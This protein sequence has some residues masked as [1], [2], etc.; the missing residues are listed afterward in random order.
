SIPEVVPTAAKRELI[1]RSRVMLD[2][3]KMIGRVAPSDSTILILG[4]SGTGK[5]MIARE[6]HALSRR[7]A[8]KFVA[9]NCGALTETLLESELFGHV[10]GAFTGAA[11]DRRGLFEEANG[12]TIFLDEV[13]ETSF[14][15]QLK[16]LRV[17]Q[18]GEIM[19]V[20]ASTPT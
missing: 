19:P 7:S 9:V 20:G 14:A 17:L 4:Q 10:K 18:E 13:T 1:G 11:A 15:F 12:G 3:F 16:L 6:V 5:E 2:L 8:K